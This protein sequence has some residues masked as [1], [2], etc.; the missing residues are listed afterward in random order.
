MGT[1]VTISGQVYRVQL[2]DT[3]GQERYRSLIPI[4]LRDAAAAVFV[5]DITCNPSFTIVDQSLN[6][7]ESW[8]ELYK[9]SRAD[10]SIMVT[11]GNKMDLKSKQ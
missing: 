4:Y 11:C 9:E 7:L 6:D 1:N 5:F 10:K 3:A 8:I 2:W